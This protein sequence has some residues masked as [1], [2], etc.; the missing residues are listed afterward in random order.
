[1]QTVH[2]SKNNNIKN[3]VRSCIKCLF[4]YRIWGR[5]ICS[6]KD[7]AGDVL[8]V[9]NPPSFQ[10]S[11]GLLYAFYVCARNNILDLSVR[12]VVASRRRRY[13]YNCPF[14]WLSWHIIIIPSQALI[15]PS[16]PITFLQ[17]RATSLRH[18]LLWKGAAS[19]QAG[20]FLTRCTSMHQPILAR[21]IH[22]TE[23]V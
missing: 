23:R 19:Q 3:L 10:L 17:L 4:K 22:D 8:R 6:G 1:M 12:Q 20:V 7:A 5:K 18:P 11:W 16:E 14:S 21:N 2:L 13:M 9:S 15:L